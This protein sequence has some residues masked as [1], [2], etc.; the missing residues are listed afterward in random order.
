MEIGRAG[1]TTS[2]DKIVN[3]VLRKDLGSFSRS[4]FFYIFNSAKISINKMRVYDVRN[5]VRQPVSGGI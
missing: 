3:R 1:I 4:V 2:P 5:G